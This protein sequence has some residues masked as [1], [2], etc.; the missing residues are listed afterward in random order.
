MS[1]IL[2][3]RCR[4]C[5]WAIEAVINAEDDEVYARTIERMRWLSRQHNAT[6]L[7]VHLVQGIGEYVTGGGD[8]ASSSKVR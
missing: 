6:P 3:A 5:G 4:H 8:D 7:G 1:R 2:A